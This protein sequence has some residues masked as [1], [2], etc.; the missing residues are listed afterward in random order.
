[1]VEEGTGTFPARWQQGMD[2]PWSQEHKDYLIVVAWGWNAYGNKSTGNPRNCTINH[3]EKLGTYKES[4]AISDR[5][6]EQ[7][8]EKGETKI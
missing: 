4:E 3:Y 2:Q 8:K 1:M 5:K 7:E 6:R